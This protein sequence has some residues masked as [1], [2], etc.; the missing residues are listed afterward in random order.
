MRT[1][2]VWKAALTDGRAVQQHLL[3]VAPVVVERQVPGAGVHVLDEARLLEAA[4]QQAFGGFGGGDG[5]GQ[6][7]GQRLPVQ[8]LHK[9]ELDTQG[10]EGGGGRHPIRRERRRGNPSTRRNG[11]SCGGV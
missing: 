10:G 1:L 2:R 3:Q 6:R 9:V 8:E 7:P 4:Q 5:V 11:P